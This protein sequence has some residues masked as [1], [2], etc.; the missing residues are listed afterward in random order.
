[1]SKQSSGLH[2]HTILECSHS[3]CFLQMNDLESS[4]V[5][6]DLHSQA[7]LKELY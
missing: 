4:V 3:I 5:L 1:M 2:Q 7:K 6:K